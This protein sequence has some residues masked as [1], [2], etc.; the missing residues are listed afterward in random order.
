MWKHS[1]ALLRP[2][3]SRENINNLDVT[4]EAA[5]AL[6]R[7][8]GKP[9]TKTGWTPGGD[10]MPLFFCFTMDT[11]TDFLFGENVG[12]LA[13]VEK[14]GNTSFESSTQ[15]KVRQGEDGDGATAASKEFA[16]AMLIAGNMTLWRIRFSSLYWIVDGLE[17]RRAIRTVWRF[18]DGF[19]DKAIAKAEAPG[20]K[21]TTEGKQARGLLEALVAQTNDR[22]DLVSQSLG[23]FMLYISY[24]VWMTD[25][26]YSGNVSRTRQ[27]GWPARLVSC[28]PR[29][30]PGHLLLAPR[31][32]PSRLPN[33]L[34]ADVLAIEILPATAALRP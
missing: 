31:D 24:A 29:P 15:A 30:A 10:A 34:S 26:N 2:F 5:D 12:A 1:R 8:L 25:Q 23:T 20:G 13:A 17:F 7:T 6:I 27:H 18:V 11:A 4:S 14:T 9:D 3:F 21:G 16:D 22:K 32:N 33:R 19:V 28:P